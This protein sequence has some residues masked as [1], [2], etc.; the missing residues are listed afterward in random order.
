MTPRWHNVTYRRTSLLSYAAWDVVSVIGFLFPVATYFGAGGFEVLQWVLV[1]VFWIALLFGYMSLHSL[2]KSLPIAIGVDASS[3]YMDVSIHGNRKSVLVYPKED[4][5]KLRI[6]L[7]NET[8]MDRQ[9]SSVF[10]SMLFGSN[11]ATLVTVEVKDRV[12]KMHSRPF[13]IERKYSAIWKADSWFGGYS[14]C[15]V[16]AQRRNGVK[17]SFLEIL[18]TIESITTTSQSVAKGRW[19]RAANKLGSVSWMVVVRYSLALFFSAL[20]A[21][22]LSK[23]SVVAGV[24]SFAVCILL[25]ILLWRDQSRRHRRACPL[26]WCIDGP[27]VH[28]DQ[29]ALLSRYE[30]R[31]VS[32]P[33]RSLEA[34]VI[35]DATIVGRTN[36]I[37]KY[38]TSFAL[39][40]AR[41]RQYHNLI[42]I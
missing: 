25:I 3:L 17:G 32:V 18:E 7:S 30:K 13:G 36:I 15:S 12:A 20:L 28:L 23:D 19:Y 40:H 1:G 29:S 2:R 26:G 9:R 31:V 16:P 33:T 11:I 27:V 37:E 38:L 42:R 22:L 10:F 5:R 4:I 41:L 24:C 21:L 35:R 14:Q 34:L 6:D 8:P 39:S